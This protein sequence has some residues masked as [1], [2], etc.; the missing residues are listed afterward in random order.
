MS[1][2]VPESGCTY[3]RARWT[4]A[5]H[6]LCASGFLCMHKNVRGARHMNAHVR[7]TRAERAGTTPDT[8]GAHAGYSLHVQRL[9]S[10]DH[11]AHTQ[12]TSNA[13]PVLHARPFVPYA[14]NTLAFVG[15]LNMC[16]VYA[17]CMRT[18]SALATHCASVVISLA[19]PK[20]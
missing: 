15:F 1:I 10:N 19:S 18:S 17:L 16:S 13:C 11:L 9:K 3:I 12:Q 6:S 4:N 2:T 14:S 20:S 5:M 8:S 7:R